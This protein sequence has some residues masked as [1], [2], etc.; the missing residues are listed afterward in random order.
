MSKIESKY[1]VIST[2][3]SV[4][5]APSPKSEGLPLLIFPSSSIAIIEQ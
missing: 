1:P 3:S 4:L 5:K 2:R